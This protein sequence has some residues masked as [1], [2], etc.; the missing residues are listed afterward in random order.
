M[1]QAIDRH[2]KGHINHVVI[3]KIVPLVAKGRLQSLLEAGAR[4]GELGCGGGNLLVAMARRFPRSQFHGYEISDPALDLARN[5]VAAEGLT[6]IIIHD[7]RD[8]PIS[9][10]E[11]KL[12]VV[13]TYDVI[14]DATDP[15]SF[16]AQVETSLRPG[17]IWLLA[18]IACQPSLRK[19]VTC[20]PVQSATY[21]AVSTCL[22]LA[23][24]MGVKGGA[25]LGTLGFSVPVARRMLK[26]AGFQTIN[27]LTE[28][29]NTRWFEV[30]KAKR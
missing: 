11:P 22:C 23:S 5:S 27:V 18:D 4:V 26:K 14:H 8:D 15:A 24:G 29:D 3:P 12:D 28:V 7:A 30:F 13:L 6:N 21:F 16:V 10:A 19:S 2:H 17:G 9:A 20:V 25:G 1:T